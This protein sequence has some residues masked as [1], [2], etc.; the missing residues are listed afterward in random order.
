MFDITALVVSVSDPRPGGAGR[1]VRDVLLMDGSKSQSDN[2]LVEM[3]LSLWTN[4]PPNA[5]QSA[6]LK[7]LTEDGYSF[8]TA[9]DL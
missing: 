5:K 1:E 3:K 7:L 2:R 9:K 8:D 4:S 6:H